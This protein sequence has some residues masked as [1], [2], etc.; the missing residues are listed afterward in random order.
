[1]M[2]AVQPQAFKQRVTRQMLAKV[3]K[4]AAVFNASWIHDPPWLFYDN[5]KGEMFCKLC[6][7]YNKRPLEKPVWN[8]QPCKRIR[9]DSVRKQDAC[10]SH[11]DAVTLEANSKVAVSPLE[12]V[13]CPV[14]RNAMRQAFAFH[15]LLVQTPDTTHNELRAASRSAVS[16]WP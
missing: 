8:E 7:K 3:G 1:M 5:I 10:H 4:Q 9:L 12:K 15:V 11:R 2:A 14:S 13:Q 6:I 16:A